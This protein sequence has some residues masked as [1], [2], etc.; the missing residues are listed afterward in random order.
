MFAPGHL[1]IRT[2]TR[3]LLRMINTVSSLL[4]FT[5]AANHLHVVPSSRAWMIKTGLLKLQ[6]NQCNS[7]FVDNQESFFFELML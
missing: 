3:Y 4:I 7:E 5:N 2:S 1:I 6:H